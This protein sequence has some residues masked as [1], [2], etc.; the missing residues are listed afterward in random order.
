MLHGANYHVVV[1]ARSLYERTNQ[2]NRNLT[3]SKKTL[4]LS[5]SNFKK[6]LISFR[7][8]A[9]DN[10]IVTLTFNV[11]ETNALPR[12]SQFVKKRL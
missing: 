6:P 5:F 8:K 7:K 3:A 2:G 10:R 12:S 1:N 11:M 4:P 9:Y